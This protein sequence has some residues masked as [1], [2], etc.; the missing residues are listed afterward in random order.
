AVQGFLQQLSLHLASWEVTS[1]LIGEYTEAEIRNNPVFTVADGILW[2]RQAV[3]RNSTVR[4][5]QVL[6]LRGQAPIP[7]LHTFRITHRGLQ[8][9]PRTEVH[10]EPPALPRPT[11]RLST[12]VERL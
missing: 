4:K 12:G 7:G 5:L 8:V 10:L 6:K 1:F 2:L 3:E 9:F 11:G